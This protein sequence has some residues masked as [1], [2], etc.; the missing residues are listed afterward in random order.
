MITYSTYATPRGDLGEAFHEFEPEGMTF[1]ADQILVPYGVQK[2]AATITVIT[3]E[4]M[5]SDDT[6]RAEGG[7]FNRIDI[8]GEDLSYLCKN[9]GLEIPITDTERRRYVDDF[10][11]E[12]EKIAVLRLRMKIARELRVKAA[13]FNTTTWTGAP[14]YTD[15]STDW[16]NI[17][18]DIIGDVVAAKE[19]VRAGTGVKPNALIVGEGAVNNMIKNT[20]IKARF[21]QNVLVTVELLRTQLASLFGLSKLIV[22]D[23]V[24]NTADEGQSFSGSDIWPDDYA[25][26]ARVAEGPG[27]PITT[28]CVGRTLRWRD[29]ESNV[30]GAPEQYREEQTKSEIYR[31]EDYIQ[32]KIIDPY[33]AH[34][35]LIDT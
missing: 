14:L 20:A 30:D 28:P 4:N 18:S 22:G 35:M 34:L 12:L 33:F 6:L 32:E 23:A 25:M 11:V 13:I 26:V 1:I 17:A 19:K 3:R 29:M 16:D 9:Y 7:G 27:S 21:Q 8:T 31:V 10:Q 2:E 5:R 15:T 24:Y